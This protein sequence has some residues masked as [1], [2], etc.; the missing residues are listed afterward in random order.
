MRGVVCAYAYSSKVKVTVLYLVVCRLA[1]EVH[2][3]VTLPLPQEFQVDVPNIPH[4]P[5]KGVHR[6]IFVPCDLYIECSDF[7]EVRPFLFHTLCSHLMKF[8]RDLVLGIY[9]PV[10]GLI[11]CG[12]TPFRT[13]GT[14][15]GS[16]HRTACHSGIYI[17]V[18]DSAHQSKAFDLAALAISI[19]TLFQLLSQDTSRADNSLLKLHTE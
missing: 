6:V 8:M 10:S 17:Y 2:A 15:L 18:S 14:G 5:D 3:R 7:R 11:L 1:E 4:I 16:G 19:S 12:Q 9:N 13:E